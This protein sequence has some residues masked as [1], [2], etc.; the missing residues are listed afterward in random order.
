M[1]SAEIS[2]L[3]HFAELFC[4]SCESDRTQL[5]R[6]EPP[7]LTWSSDTLSTQ[8]IIPF[9]IVGRMK[10]L[11]GEKYTKL[12]KEALNKMELTLINQGKL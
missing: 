9:F 2:D 1:L 6:G 5:R 4:K 8:P 7:V 11:R 3:A 10:K 12:Q